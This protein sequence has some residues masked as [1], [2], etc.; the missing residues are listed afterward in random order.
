MKIEGLFILATSA[1]MKIMYARHLF[2]SC[3]FDWIGLDLTVYTY[4][5]TVFVEEYIFVAFTLRSKKKFV[6]F[7]LEQLFR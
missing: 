2:R 1:H 3:G 7:M 5:S 6:S 4:G